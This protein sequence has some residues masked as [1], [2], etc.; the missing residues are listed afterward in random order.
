M[1]QR[2]AGPAAPPLMTT[3]AVL[4]WAGSTLFLGKDKSRRRC[5]AARGIGQGAASVKHRLRGRTAETPH[6]AGPLEQQQVVE[7]R[8]RVLYQPSLCSERDL[9]RQASH[10]R[11]DRRADD[12]VEELAHGVASHDQH[13]PPLVSGNVREPDVT[14][15]RRGGVHSGSM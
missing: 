6:Q 11:R 13:R 7:V 1:T 12:R 4:S 10:G 5:A 9:G 8:D 3:N 15:S 14:A 2:R